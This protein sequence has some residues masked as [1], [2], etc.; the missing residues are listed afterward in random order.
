MLM[1]MFRSDDSS[2]KSFWQIHFDASYDL[3]SFVRSLIGFYENR[4]QFS[5]VNTITLIAFA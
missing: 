2:M 4:N 3:S 5:K 1:Q